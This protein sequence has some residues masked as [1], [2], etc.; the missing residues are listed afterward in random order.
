MG[1]GARRAGGATL[2]G[3]EA[4]FLVVDDQPL[5]CRVVS[6]MLK[7]AGLSCKTLNNGAEA[8]A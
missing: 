5:P 3:R 4:D 2:M 7:R 1:G 6:N 8:V